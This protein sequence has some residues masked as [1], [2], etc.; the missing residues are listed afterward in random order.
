[1]VCITKG[2][3]IKAE[4]MAVRAM[5]TRMEALGMEY[6]RTLNSIELVGVVFN[7]QRKY[8]EA[9]AM[10]RQAL[11]GREKNAR[12]KSPRHADEH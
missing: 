9:E 11:E 5:E 10:H 3:T 2:S 6:K 7:G 8:E 1:M 12:N 4:K